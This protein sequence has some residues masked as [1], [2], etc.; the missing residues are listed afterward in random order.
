[1]SEPLDWAQ[2]IDALRSEND[3][4]LDT[5]KVKRTI[6]CILKEAEDIER[7][8]DELIEQIL[9]TDIESNRASGESLDAG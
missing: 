4:S 9:T 8:D 1:M 5:A 7:I 3:P 2:A 6:G